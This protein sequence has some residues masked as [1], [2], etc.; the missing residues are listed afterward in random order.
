MPLIQIDNFGQGGLNLDLQPY[1][2]PPHV[3]SGGQNI[4]FNKKRLLK[5]MGSRAIYPSFARLLRTS[6]N[7]AGIVGTNLLIHNPGGLFITSGVI[8]GD[9][10]LNVTDGLSTL[11]AADPVAEVTLELEDHIF[12]NADGDA[13]AIYAGDE[14]PLWLLPWADGT[15]NYWIAPTKTAIMLIDKTTT[16]DVSRTSG[17]AY[18]GVTGTIWSGGI[19]GGVPILNNDAGDSP[20]SWDG[21]TGKFVDL[22]NWTSGASVKIMRV[23]KQYLIGYDYT[24]NGGTREPYTVKWSNPAL[25]GTVP[26]KWDNADDNDSNE[27]PLSENDGFILD[28]CPLRDFMV[29]YRER[30]IYLQQL[31][32]SPFVFSFRKVFEDIGILAPRCVQEF[33]GKHFVVTTDDIIV[34]DGQTPVSVA[35]DRV[36]DWFFSNLQVST[37]RQTYVAAK[38]DT[39]EMWV[40]F[41]SSGIAGTYPDTALIWNWSDNT[42]GIRELPNC[43]HI[44]YGIVDDEGVSDIID[45]QEQFIDSDESIID[46]EPFGAGNLGLVA[47][48]TE[49]ADLKL[50]Q[51]DSTEQEFGTDMVSRAER[52]G[53]A[54]VGRDQFGEWKVDPAS[55]KFLRRIWLKMESTGPVTVYF[56]VQQ[57]L[58]GAVEWTSGY[59][60]TPGV[61]PH[62]DTRLHGKAFGIKIESATDVAWS[63]TGATFDMEIIGGET[64]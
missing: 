55:S 23:F 30:S 48:T 18:A 35:D 24:P 52:T 58:E 31:T 50:L 61:T 1:Q 25:P 15:T 16:L 40:C 44:Q 54:M 39:Q 7:I 2:L 5:S 45:D 46:G 9:L 60:Y 14:Y 28:A 36:R 21:G 20:Q 11:A 42:W 64:R 34:H 53:L 43:P 37:K 51:L 13:Y 12:P 41:I 57:Q 62:L 17:G 3:W 63:C 56:G 47:S 33:N 29:V 19:L 49:T 27:Q 6:G 4:R 38:Y 10:V 22:P 26:T 59:S 32:N 8:E